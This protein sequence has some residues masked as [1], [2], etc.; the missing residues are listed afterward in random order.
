[1]IIRD[2]QEHYWDLVTLQ[3]KLVILFS[4]S[5]EEQIMKPWVPKY[6]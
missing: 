2:F 4:Q 3:A 5:P 6:I 1:M